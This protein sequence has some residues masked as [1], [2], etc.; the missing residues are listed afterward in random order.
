MLCAQAIPHVL[1]TL[2][3]A[4]DPFL[5]EH[6]AVFVDGG[7]FL[8]GVG[9]G[10]VGMHTVLAAV[11]KWSGSASDQNAG[12]Q[13]SLSSRQQEPVFVSSGPGHP[14]FAPARWPRMSPI[15]CCASFGEILPVGSAEASAKNRSF[16]TSDCQEAYGSIEPL[17]S[18]P[19]FVRNYQRRREEGRTRTKVT[20]TKSDG[21]PGVPPPLGSPVLLMKPKRL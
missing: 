5:R 17:S 14:I 7:V 4:P 15:P 21:V 16:F 2:M 11:H 9:I 19:R 10:L 3:S 6:Q 18:I 13:P 1:H 8:A 12:E 20:V